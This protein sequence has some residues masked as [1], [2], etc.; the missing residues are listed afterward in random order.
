MAWTLKVKC[1]EDIRRYPFSERPTY[2]EVHTAISGAWPGKGAHLAKYL[3]QEG[4]RC[5]LS[6][7]TFTDFL[8]TSAATGGNLYVVRLAAFNIVACHRPGSTTKA[9]EQHPGDSGCRDPIRGP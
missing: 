5:T 7:D 3:D 1:G 2:R 4:D 9:Q 6:E 8:E